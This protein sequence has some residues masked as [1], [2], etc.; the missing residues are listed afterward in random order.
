[1]IN[2]PVNGNNIT[3]NLPRWLDDDFTFLRIYQ[4]SQDKQIGLLFQVR[5]KL[6]RQTMSSMLDRKP[7]V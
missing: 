7:A 5:N 2:V 4:A 1:M 3:H 6:G